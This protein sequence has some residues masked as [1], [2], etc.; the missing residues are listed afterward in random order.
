MK[1]VLILDNDHGI[2][3]V[4][5]EALN[6]EGYDVKTIA[7]CESIFPHIDE[8]Q[9]DLLLIDY[10]LNGVNGGEICHQ[11]KLNK[12]TSSIPVIMMSAYPR[13]IESLGNYGCN[14]FVAKPFDLH[15]LMF[16]IAQLTTDPHKT[17]HA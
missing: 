8:Y 11:V 2:L 1:K 15:D 4:M 12:R 14:A 13:I 7:D 9:P 10:I 16:R 6:Y 17:L 5:R 3:E